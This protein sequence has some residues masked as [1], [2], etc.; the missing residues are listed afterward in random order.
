MFGHLRL[1]VTVLLFTPSAGTSQITP[2]KVK[3]WFK[4]GSGIA[5]APLSP[6]PCCVRL[7][8][9]MARSIPAACCCFFIRYNTRVL[10]DEIA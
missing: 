10:R 2:V 4:S 3:Q 1:L 7:K 5:F 6:V 9:Q 8:H